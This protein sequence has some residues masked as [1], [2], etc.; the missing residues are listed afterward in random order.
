MKTTIL[1]SAVV[2]VFVFLGATL[3]AQSNITNNNQ[4]IGKAHGAAAQCLNNYSGMTITARVETAG[5]CFDF[6]SLRKVVFS[7]SIKCNNDP[8]CEEVARMTALLIA[9]VYFDCDDNVT[10]VN[11]MH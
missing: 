11:C 6:G 7:S 3:S 4:L 2:L 8:S 5:V 10:F 1:K 9:E